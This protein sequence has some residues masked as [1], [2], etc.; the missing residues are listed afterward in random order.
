MNMHVEDYRILKTAST[1][2]LY[3]L[4]SSVDDLDDGISSH[5]ED[6]YEQLAAKESDLILAAEL[7]KMLLDRNT[8]LQRA[9]ERLT[10]EYTEQNEVGCRKNCHSLKWINHNDEFCI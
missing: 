7:G 8:E 3:E 2:S 10:D 1:G 6:L 5:E 4:S 9:Q